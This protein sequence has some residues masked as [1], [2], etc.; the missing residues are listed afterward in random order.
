MMGTKFLIGRWVSPWASDPFLKIRIAI[1]I[2]TRDVVMLHHFVDRAWRRFRPDEDAYV[3]E[4]INEE[5][6]DVIECPVD[7]GLK[8]T[9]AIPAAWSDGESNALHE[10]SEDDEEVNAHDSEHA[11]ACCVLAPM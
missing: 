3:R 1:R 9:D 6:D 7:Y 2:E 5:I 11:C 8:A 4:L 10:L